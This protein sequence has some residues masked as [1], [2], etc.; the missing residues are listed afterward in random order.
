MISKTGN[1]FFYERNVHGKISEVQKS[2]S[3]LPSLL[4]PARKN[5]L[6]S[7]WLSS[8][9]GLVI[10]T[11]CLQRKS[12]VNISLQG[13]EPQNHH[14]VWAKL[15]GSPVLAVRTLAWQRDREPV[16]QSCRWLPGCPAQSHSPSLRWKRHPLES[17]RMVRVKLVIQ[18]LL[19]R[20]KSV[21][22]ISAAEK[23]V[24][25]ILIFDFNV[26]SGFGIQLFVS[27][28]K[29]IDIFK[30]ISNILSLVSKVKEKLLSILVLIIIALKAEKQKTHFTIQNEIFT[31][32]QH[33]TFI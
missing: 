7:S 16:C 25:F 13:R 2:S 24:N 14:P 32:Y 20:S 11:L 4:C 15:E 6:T 10:F 27:S 5:T 17:S 8:W 22:E 21:L 9:H 33:G 29:K 19:L 1:A 31:H 23:K 18:F 26:W 12:K 28:W 30:Y 3:S